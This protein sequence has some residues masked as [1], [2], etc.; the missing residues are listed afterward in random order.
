M[1][2]NRHENTESGHQGHHGSAAET[3]ERQSHRSEADVVR[4]TLYR[5]QALTD[6]YARMTKRLAKE[7][8]KRSAKSTDFP[9]YLEQLNER[10]SST[11][12]AML[13][14]IIGLCGGRSEDAGTITEA[15]ITEFRSQMDEIYGSVTREEFPSAVSQAT[16][17]F[18]KRASEMARSAL[19]KFTQA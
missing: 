2:V 7:A 1:S 10:H 8:V 17:G 6:V 9:D 19:L 16:E 15:L 14:P 18:E 11:L 4:E 5:V 13:E 12:R 3:D